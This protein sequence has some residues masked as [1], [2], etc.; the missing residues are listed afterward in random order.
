MGRT[1]KIEL[2]EA[3][4]R[5][6]DDALV[7]FQH[8]ILDNPGPDMVIS[9]RVQ[10]KIVAAQA[11]LPADAPE[12]EMSED[13]RVS[14]VADGIS[15][16]WYQAPTPGQVAVA[17]LRALDEVGA[18]EAN[19]AHRRVDDDWRDQDVAIADRV[20]RGKGF[21]LG[22]RMRGEHQDA[23]TT[24]DAAVRAI[25]RLLSLGSDVTPDMEALAGDGK[26][27]VLWIN[28]RA[29][30]RDAVEDLRAALAAAGAGKDAH[31]PRHVYPALTPKQADAAW[32]CKT[33]GIRRDEH[34]DQGATFLPIDD[35]AYVRA[36]EEVDREALHQQAHRLLTGRD[37]PWGGC[38]QRE[39]VERIA[40]ALAARGDAADRTI[41]AAMVYLRE[42]GMPASAI[43]L[44][45]MLAEVARGNAATPTDY[46]EP[47][48][49]A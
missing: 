30:L 12:P 38:D 27:R 16:I 20:Q 47:S 32:P 4:A 40:D 39:A 9:Q 43:V 45:G 22:W 31:D 5:V 18:L 8:W 14:I 19:D 26:W 25:A 34:S 41:R 37:E 42:R 2:T 29:D 1:I 46:I 24:D 35:H 3:Q 36:G 21:L 33:C 13:P 17:A 48:P 28:L 6:V 10:S 44:E 23:I 11:G 7:K 15:E 49:S